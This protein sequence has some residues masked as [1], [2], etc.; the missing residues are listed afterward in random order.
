MTCDVHARNYQLQA[1]TTITKDNTLQE[2][3]ELCDMHIIL[4]GK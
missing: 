1:H 4:Y 2:L 3:P